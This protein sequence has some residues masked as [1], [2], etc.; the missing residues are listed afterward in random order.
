MEDPKDASGEAR[1]TYA[2]LRKPASCMLAY[3]CVC[4]RMLAYARVCSR[5]LANARVCSCMLTYDA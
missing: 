1:F 5:M 4:L 2:R 3:A